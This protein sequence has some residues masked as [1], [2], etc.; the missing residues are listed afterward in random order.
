MA[1]FKLVIAF[2]LSVTQMLAPWFGYAFKGGIDACFDK[3]SKED[4]YTADYA[5]TLKKTEGRDF[6]IINFA[7]IQLS[8]DEVYGDEGALAEATIKKCINDLKPDLITLTGDNAWCDMGYIRIVNV[9]DS[10]GIPWAAVMG[11]HDGNNGDRLH[12]GWD[13]Y[14]L[15]NASN[16]LFRYG[17]EGMGY[18]N[19]NINI[20]QNGEIIHTVYMVDTHTST[21]LEC[22]GYDHLWDNQIDWYRWCVEGTNKL[23]GKTVESSLFFHIPNYE[24]ND[25]W[26]AAGYNAETG[27]YENPEYADSFGDMEEEI[28]SPKFKSSFFDVVKELGST[29]N[30][31]AGH[32]HV[33]NFSINY[34]GVRLSYSL[35]CGSGCYWNPE[36]N[37]CSV[38]TVNDAGE[39][40]FSHY[41]VDP[42]DVSSSSV[43]V[44]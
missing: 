42:A 22:G 31:V 25:A 8:S 38:I 33:N 9:L 30:I 7:D 1:I 11:N 3:W 10:Y 21:S 14:L 23:A 41:Y 32:D 34:Q 15:A 17:P 4:V 44:C 37:G 12:E 6:V 16:S 36:K 20:V 19:Y 26:A 39:G 27:V 13:A 35:K 28:C 18:G 5:Q 29:K 40:V 43:P 24:Y 2:F